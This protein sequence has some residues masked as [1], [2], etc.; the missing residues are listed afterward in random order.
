VRSRAADVAAVLL[1]LGEL[2]SDLEVMEF[3]QEALSVVLPAGHP[4]AAKRKIRPVH[5]LEEPLVYWDRALAP[6]AYDRLMQE[7]WPGVDRPRISHIEPDME[8]MVA[9]VKAGDGVT[10]LASARAR[11]HHVPGLVV[12]DF[13][14]PT[15]AYCYGLCWDGGTTNPAVSRFIRRVRRRAPQPA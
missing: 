12:R 6:G 11:R 1:P 15:P 14:H 2:G 7:L 8:R 9:A 5:L 13:A 3:Q 4:L 10:I